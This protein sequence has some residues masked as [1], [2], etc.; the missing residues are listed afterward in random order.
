MKYEYEITKGG[1]G[2]NTSLILTVVGH[3]LIFV[4]SI[5]AV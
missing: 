3:T 4:F 1:G 5:V 2:L